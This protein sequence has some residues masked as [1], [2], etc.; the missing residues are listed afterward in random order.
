MLLKLEINE[1][2]EDP[3]QTSLYAV[4]HL[5]LHCLPMSI[6]KDARQIWVNVLAS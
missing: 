3:D 5:A 1:T 2:S 4:S 6:K